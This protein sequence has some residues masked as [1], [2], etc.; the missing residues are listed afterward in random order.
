[1]GRVRAAY[2]QSGLSLHEL[3]IRMDFPEANARMAAWQALKAG[4][5]RIST[6]RRFA[7][8]LNIPIEDVVVE[9]P[10]KKKK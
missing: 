1:M 9:S 2:E 3:G 6:L 8:A 5:P 10:A 7:K 4:D